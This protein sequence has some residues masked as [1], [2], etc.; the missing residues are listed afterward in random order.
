MKN[1]RECA[2]GN[3]GKSLPGDLTGSWHWPLPEKPRQRIGW[4]KNWP[5]NFTQKFTQVFLQK[6]GEKISLKEKKKKQK[7][8][9][10]LLNATANAKMNFPFVCKTFPLLLNDFIQKC[11]WSNLWIFKWEIW[12]TLPLPPV[13]LRNVGQNKQFPRSPSLVTHHSPSQRFIGNQFVRIFIWL[14]WRNLYLTHMEESLSDSCGRIFIWLMWKNLYPMFASD[15]CARIK[16]KN[17]PQSLKVT[18][19]EF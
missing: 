10:F 2:P 9:H 3:L 17:W 5:K 11:W 7:S 14:M 13:R 8:C 1:N 16:M 18:N 12:A 19:K 4:P 15:S 6:S